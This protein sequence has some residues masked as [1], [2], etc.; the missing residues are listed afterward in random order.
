MPDPS[1]L[2]NMTM[3]GNVILTIAVVAFAPGTVTEFQIRVT[4]IGAAADSTAVGVGNLLLL[5]CCLGLGIKGYDLGSLRGRADHFFAEHSG[6]LS[7]P[8]QGN[9]IQNILAEEQEIVGKGNDAEEIAGEGKGEQIHQHDHQIHQREQPGLHRDNEEQ[10]ELG[11]REDG[12]IA[13]E[14][15]Q[16]QVRDAGRAAEKH[17]VHIH[18]YNAGQIEQIEPQCAPALL[19]D[20]TDRIV[21]EQRNEH[22]QGTADH[23]GQRIGEQPPDLTLQNGSAVKAKQ[24][25]QNRLSCH[26][27][28]DI[29][30]GSAKDDVK[31]QVGNALVSVFVAVQIELPSKILQNRFLL[32][33]HL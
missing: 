31:H 24:I 29:D 6:D 27:A 11:I 20:P 28:H 21:A 13:E 4:Y 2:L 10:Q 12:G 16:V 26:I 33:K 15:A 9:N 8:G 19:H 18:H 30:N 17:A 23:V 7:A 1:S 32:W 14:Q 25:I 5:G 22:Q 3:V